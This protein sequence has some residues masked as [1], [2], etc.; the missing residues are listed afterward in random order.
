M[1]N[2][3]EHIASKVMG[4]VKKGK[5]ALE[6]MNGIFRHLAQEHGEVTA[7]LLRVQSSSDRGVRTRLFTEIRRELLSHE[8]GEVEVLYPALREYSATKAIADAHDREVPPLQTA[9]S[10]LDAMDA[11]SP[12]WEPAFAGLVELVQ[13]HTS[14]E[15][16][17]WFPAAQKAV[18]KQRS[19]QLLEAFENAKKQALAEL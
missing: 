11:S 1:A 13:Q 5:A 15:E 10:N 8:K 9:I 16:N 7:L 2:P 12:G 4:T 3:V 14:E 18:G 17:E 6:G 19:E